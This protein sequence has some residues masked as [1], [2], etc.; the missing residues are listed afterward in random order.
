[1]RTKTR[2]E[3]LAAGFDCPYRVL[4]LQCSGQHAI[5]VFFLGTLGRCRTKRLP[6]FRITI[7]AAAAH[8]K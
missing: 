8:F 7:A 3:P 4:R 1:M 5:L 6:S 2:K